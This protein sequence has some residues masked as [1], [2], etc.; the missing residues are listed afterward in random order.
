MIT[1]VALGL[2]ILYTTLAQPRTPPHADLPA[3][4][5]PAG[6]LA[7]GGVL[8][9]AQGW[10]TGWMLAHVAVQVGCMLLTIL[11]CCMLVLINQIASH[12]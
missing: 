10:V 3:A 8:H 9:V 2:V 4:K 11:Q 12:D 1:V 6:V 7:S 5:G